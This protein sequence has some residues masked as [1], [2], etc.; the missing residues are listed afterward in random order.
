MGDDVLINKLH[1]QS[2]GFKDLVNCLR[3]YSVRLLYLTDEV[4][5]LRQRIEELTAIND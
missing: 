2:E 3:F 5:R 4:A 1:G